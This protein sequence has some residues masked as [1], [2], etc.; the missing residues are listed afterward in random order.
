V[1]YLSEVDENGMIEVHESV[2]QYFKDG[3]KK[4]DIWMTKYRDEIDKLEEEN[5]VLKEKIHSWGL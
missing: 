2:L 1:N 3:I 5:R 4:C